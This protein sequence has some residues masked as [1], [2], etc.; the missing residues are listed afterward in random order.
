MQ[1]IITV[2]GATG[3]GKSDFAVKLAKRFNGEVISADS[4]QIYKGLNLSTGKITPEEMSGVPHHLLNIVP[5]GKPYSVYNFKHHATKAIADISSRGKLPIICGG[6]GLY[7]RALVE[8]FSLTER[9]IDNA[10][11]SELEEKTIEELQQIIA[12]NNIPLVET[13]IKNKRRLISAIVKYK[14]NILEAENAPEYN[15][16]QICLTIPREQQRER[17]KARLKARLDAGMLTEIEEAIKAGADPEFLKTLGLDMRYSV[18]QLNSEFKN[19][20]EFFE[21][22]FTKEC[23]YAKRQQTWFKK[24]KNCIYIN[25]LEESAFETACTKIKNFLGE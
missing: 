2:I 17:I 4:R 20:D 3:S 24:E 18:M 7:T 8:G 5:L 23:Q 12:T 6:T 14:Y 22:L 16:L 21:T 10:V 25:P 9:N 15:A 1:K 13:D 19:Y 11:A